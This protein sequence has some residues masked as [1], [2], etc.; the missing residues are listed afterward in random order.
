MWLLTDLEKQLRD[1][2]R[3]G[4]SYHGG[5]GGL[6]NLFAQLCFI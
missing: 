3:R 2:E 6:K 4:K 1:G 5:G